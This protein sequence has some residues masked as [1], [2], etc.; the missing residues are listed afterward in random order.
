M[1]RRELASGVSQRRAGTRSRRKVL[2]AMCSNTLGGLL[3]Q[4]RAKFSLE[5]S[6]DVL[7]G[8]SAVNLCVARRLVS[9]S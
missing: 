1:G 2:Q 6:S 8:I 5:T 7:E 3:L 9:V 4:R